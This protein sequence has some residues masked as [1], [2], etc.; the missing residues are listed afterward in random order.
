MTISNRGN[1]NDEVDIIMQPEGQVC[2]GDT[3]L[4]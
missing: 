3:S 4:L 2:L 1:T